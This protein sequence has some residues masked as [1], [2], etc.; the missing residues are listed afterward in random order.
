MDLGKVVRI[1][2][3]VIQWKSITKPY[4]I[5]ICRDEAEGWTEIGRFTTSFNKQE[6]VLT[7]TDAQYVQIRVETGGPC[8]ICELEVYE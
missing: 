2:E 4:I 5:E 1:S 6:S 3:V 8:A 7:D